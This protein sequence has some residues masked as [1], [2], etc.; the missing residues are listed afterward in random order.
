MMCL[1]TDQVD[2][3][4]TFSHLNKDNDF[5]LRVEIKIKK[6]LPLNRVHPGN[7]AY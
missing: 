7:R 4:F 6:A 3:R 5:D 1:L 2:D